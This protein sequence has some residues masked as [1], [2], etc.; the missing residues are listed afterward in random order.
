MKIV[1]RQVRRVAL[2]ATFGMA[3]AMTGAVVTSTP[4]YDTN[5]DVADVAAERAQILLAGADCDLPDGKSAEKCV[6]HMKKA[7]ALLSRVRESIT[8]STPATHGLR[9]AQPARN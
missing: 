4:V 5:L 7:L 9:S 2:G 8:Q 1:Q 3:L 6:R